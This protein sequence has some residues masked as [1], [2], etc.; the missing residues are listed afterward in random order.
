MKRIGAILA[1]LLLWVFAA[2]ALADTYSQDGST[3]YYDTPYVGKTAES[4][5]VLRAS[6]YERGQIVSTLRK[7]VKLTITAARYAKDNTLWYE[8]QTSTKKQGWVLADQV[9]FDQVDL[10][11]SARASTKGAYIGNVNTHVAHRPN[12]RAL[13]NA[14]NRER[15]ASR[16]AALL[17]GYRP[18]AICRPW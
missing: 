4:D 7:G 3:I 18:C 11:R 15:F 1:A 5:V 9:L 8:A 10:E 13:P 12:C 17:A 14:G 16:Q 6:A 2:A